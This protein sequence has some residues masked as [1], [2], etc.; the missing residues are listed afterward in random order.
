MA[1][2]CIASG[3][4]TGDTANAQKRRKDGAEAVQVC[5]LGGSHLWGGF[6]RPAFG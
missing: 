3:G 2:G 1:S 5:G 4:G 6:W